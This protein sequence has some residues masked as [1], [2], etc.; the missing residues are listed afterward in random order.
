MIRI[1]WQ[2]RKGRIDSRSGRPGLMVNQ[3]C[4]AE[5]SNVN[6][7]Y[8]KAVAGRLPSLQAT[9]HGRYLSGRNLPRRI[10]DQRISPVATLPD[11]VKQREL[12]L[13]QGRGRA[14]AFPAGDMP[15]PVPLRSESPPEHFF[16]H[17]PAPTES[18]LLPIAPVLNLHPP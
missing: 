10:T 16:N 11:G 6:C 1:P 15:R 17:I 8:L 18:Q 7:C 14:L 3:F 12:L 5:S 13:P 9:C 4:L 2:N